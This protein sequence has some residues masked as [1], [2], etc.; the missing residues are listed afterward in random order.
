MNWIYTRWL[1]LRF[2]WLSVKAMRLR[3]ELKQMRQE[4]D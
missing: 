2:A 3:H 1:E 4:M